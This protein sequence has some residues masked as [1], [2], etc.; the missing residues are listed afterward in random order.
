MM[1]NLDKIR[2]IKDKHIG[3]WRQL[4]GFISAG[5]GIVRGDEE[6]IILQVAHITPEIREKVPD[7]I[8]DVPVKLQEAEPFRAL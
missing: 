1:N 3:E 7:H 2:A 8:D 5:I 6:G 4:P